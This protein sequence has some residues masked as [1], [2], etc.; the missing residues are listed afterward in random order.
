MTSKERRELTVRVTG[1]VGS[2]KFRELADINV[3][4]RELGWQQFDS[5]TNSVCVSTRY[6]TLTCRVLSRMTISLM[7]PR[8][9]IKSGTRCD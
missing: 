2:H 8:K 4:V 1:F 9:V 5:N 3:Q 7:S 6:D